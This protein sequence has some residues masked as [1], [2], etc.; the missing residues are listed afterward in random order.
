VNAPFDF[1]GKPAQPA[2]SNSS[3]AG[4]CDGA[5]AVEFAI[6]ATALILLLLGIIQF[7]WVLWYQSTLQQAVEATARYCSII[8][9]S[10]SPCTTSNIQSTGTSYMLGVFSPTFTLTTPSCGTQVSASATFTSVLG[11]YVPNMTVSSQSCYP[12]TP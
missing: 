3:L 7:G 6:A 4:A 1:P 5:V 12:N 9:A 10:G 8:S 2:R 11:G